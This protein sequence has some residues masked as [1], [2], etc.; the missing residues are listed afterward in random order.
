MSIKGAPVGAD[1]LAIWHA[2]TVPELA[3]ALRYVYG[4][5]SGTD[6]G[7]AAEI[8]ALEARMNALEAEN[9]VQTGRLDALEAQVATLETDYDALSTDLDALEARVAALE[10]PAP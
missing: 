10:A 5:L 3:D 7:Q 4:Q 2:R 1:G 6:T 8:A 9:G